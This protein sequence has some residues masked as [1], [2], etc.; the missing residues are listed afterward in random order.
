M[1]FKGFECIFETVGRIKPIHKIQKLRWILAIDQGGALPS[2]LPENEDDGI[3]NAEK[4]PKTVGRPYWI[5][6]I[7]L[8]SGGYA[9]LRT[10]FLKNGNIFLF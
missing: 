10:T 9:V 1:R 7:L 2:E 3:A 8:Q 6:I 5:H 4:Y